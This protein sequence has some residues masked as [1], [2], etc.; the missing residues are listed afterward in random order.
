MVCNGS[1]HLPG[2]PKLVW[3]PARLIKEGGCVDLSV[4]TMH[5]KD[6]LILFLDLK[7]LLF[8]FVFFFFHI[9]NNL[10]HCF[11]PITTDHFFEKKNV[12]H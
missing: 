10:C 3:H 8:L 12:W 9:L 11:S 1:W 6:P 4:D 5:L 2:S 7:A